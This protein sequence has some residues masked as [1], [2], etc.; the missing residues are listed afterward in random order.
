MLIFSCLSLQAQVVD[1]TKVKDAYAALQSAAKPA[2][3]D[4]ATIGNVAGIISTGADL[5]HY[6]VKVT[7]L[8]TSEIDVTSAAA[9]AASAVPD[10]HT[11]AQD[12]KKS[13]DGTN[14]TLKNI[15][16]ALKQYD[17]DTT[18]MREPI[19]NFYY[20]ITAERI[21]LYGFSDTFRTFID[22]AEQAAGKVAHDAAKSQ[23]LMQSVDIVTR[24]MQ[25]MIKDLEAYDASLK[26]GYEYVE[27]MDK[28]CTPLKSAGNKIATIE[29]RLHDME[30]PLKNVVATLDRSV[31]FEFP[32]PDPELKHPL[33]EG[34][35][36][37]DISV[38]KALN[39]AEFIEKEIE[40]MLS[41]FLWKMLKEFGLEKALK[42]LENDAKGLMKDALS[43]LDMRVDLSIPGIDNVE[44][45][46][47]ELKSE[48]EKLSKLQLKS[49]FG[50]LKNGVTAQATQV[51]D[52]LKMMK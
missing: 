42:S 12:L 36:R 35:Y 40:K 2:H 38:R 31:S 25:D 52:I 37:I 7:E 9:D 13:L 14:S 39:G 5:P 51:G 19:D 23:K 18:P 17:L 6:M 24:L 16:V 45:N 27:G 33:H 34:H 48:L 29:D 15:L 26:K 1:L 30:G 43:K 47:S 44:R 41:K 8:L 10:I 28:Y 3:D 22:L 11:T 50:D 20:A 4:I 46:E 49:L 32:Y 21:A